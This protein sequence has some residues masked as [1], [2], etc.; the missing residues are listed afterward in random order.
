MARRSPAAVRAALPRRLR[1]GVKLPVVDG[2]SARAVNE[3]Q[4]LERS[5]SL[6]P[7]SVARALADWRHAVHSDARHLLDEAVRHGCPCCD[8]T[9]AR[10]VLE[11]ALTKLG[12]RSRRALSAKVEPL[13]EA[14][15]R[16]TIHDPQT[17]PDWPWWRRRA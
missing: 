10:G 1:P 17:P 14:F 8:P 7:G 9:E 6:P 16:R 13:D 2:L 12:P 4:V 15:R 11:L 3:I 5:E